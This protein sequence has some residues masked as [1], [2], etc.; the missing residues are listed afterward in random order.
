MADVRL[1]DLIA[2][3]SAEIWDRMQLLAHNYK[4]HLFPMIHTQPQYEQC[5]GKLLEQAQYLSIMLLGKVCPAALD[6][7]PHALHVGEVAG[8][9]TLLGEQQHSRLCLLDLPCPE[10][11]LGCLTVD[12]PATSLKCSER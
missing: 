8:A 6:L 4:T 1:N 11:P 10:H 5:F 2:G 3:F 7:I 9:V 12:V